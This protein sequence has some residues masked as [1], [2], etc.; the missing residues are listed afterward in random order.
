MSIRNSSFEGKRGRSC[1]RIEDSANITLDNCNMG[2][3]PFADVPWSAAGMWNARIAQA[4]LSIVWSIFALA[5]MM[6]AHRLRFRAAWVGG[7]ALLAV[8]VGKLFFVDLSQ[9]GGVERI[10]SF[11][12]VGVLLLI[13]GYVAPVPPRQ[14]SA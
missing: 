10:V 9:V 7:A 2:G 12:G 5:S 3:G 1:I 6:I 8:V 11:M 13:I 14:E 4:A